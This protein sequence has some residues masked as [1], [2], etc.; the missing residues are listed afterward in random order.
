[1]L[2]ARGDWPIL[3][4]RASTDITLHLPTNAVL[5][6]W[7]V[8]LDGTRLYTVPLEAAVDGWILHVQTDGE[9]GAQLAYEI[10]RQ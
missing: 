9:Q 8:G 1:M 5:T 10:I 7:A 2:E 6:A 3:V 4:Q